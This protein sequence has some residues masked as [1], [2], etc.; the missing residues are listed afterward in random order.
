MFLRNISVAVFRESCLMNTRNHHGTGK[1][2]YPSFDIQRPAMFHNV[3]NPLAFRLLDNWK[4]LVWIFEMFLGTWYAIISPSSA[5]SS[6]SMVRSANH[7][8]VFIVATSCKHVLTRTTLMIHQKA[9]ISNQKKWNDT[10]PTRR[11]TLEACMFTTV[12][13]THGDGPF[14]H[15][16]FISHKMQQRQNTEKKQKTYTLLLATV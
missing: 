12:F 6:G 4:I 11:P 5:S 8:N 1:D 3:W 10:S 13:W 15:K 9:S 2:C 7:A 16:H 14:L